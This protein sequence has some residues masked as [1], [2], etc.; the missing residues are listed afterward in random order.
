MVGI[1]EFVWDLFP[2]GKQPG[3]APVNFAYHLTC[4][5]DEG[6]PVTA[7]GQDP[8]GAEAIALFE[9]Q[10]LTTGY[11]QK[12]A[13]KPTGTVRV[14]VDARGQPT[15]DIREQVAWDFLE[16]TEPLRL[17][18]PRVDV[19]CFGSLAQRSPFSRRTTR[20][21]LDDLPERVLR[22][23]DV[24]LRQS[25]FEAATLRESLRRAH[26]V[27]L[28]HDELPLVCRL[29]QLKAP[30]EPEAGARTLLD[31]FSLRLVCVTR[32][33][34]GSLLVSH[35]GESFSHPGFPTRVVDTVGAGDAFTA[36]LTHF[37]VRGASLEVLSEA[38]NRLGSWVASQAGATPPESPAVA[39]K[40]LEQ[41]GGT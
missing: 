26:L 7:V 41:L 25:F 24:N 16:Y 1:G 27:K 9:S 30:E 37:Y 20:R 4:L 10:G 38:G 19:I 40:I 33:G 14:S 28:N 31:A 35:D 5:G 17:L 8:L 15:F 34:G 22:I 39:G 29:L 23:F 11:V 36:A 13:G 6:I 32:G 12:P 21:F 18:G 2:S 3:G